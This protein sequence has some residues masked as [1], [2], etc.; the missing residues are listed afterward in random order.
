[1]SVGRQKMKRIMGKQD[2]YMTLICGAFDHASQLM[3]CNYYMYVCASIDIC[4][5]IECQSLR[6]LDGSSLCVALYM[7]W[8]PIVTKMETLCL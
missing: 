2:S 8:G 7:H 6:L 5:E 4:M 3:S 1:M